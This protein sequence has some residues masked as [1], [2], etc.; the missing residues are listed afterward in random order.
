MS[1]HLGEEDKT[2]PRYV[3]RSSTIFDTTLPDWRV[4][5]VCDVAEDA[6]TI[7]AGMNAIDYLKEM[8]VYF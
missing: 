1:P 4:V 5:C 8:G 7:A 3:V 6:R 2:F